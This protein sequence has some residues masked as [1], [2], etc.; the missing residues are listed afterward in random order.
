MKNSRIN[1]LNNNGQEIHRLD[2][3]KENTSISVN[4]SSADLTTFY[5]FN[6]V[7]NHLINSNIL[8]AFSY[9]VIGYIYIFLGQ[10]EI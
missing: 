2:T 5:S 3:L 9:A 1:E 10:Y 7:S 4:E 6:F 8:L